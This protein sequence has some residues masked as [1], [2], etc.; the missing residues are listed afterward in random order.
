MGNNMKHKTIRG[1]ISYTSNQPK[2]KGQERG[3]ES[4]IVTIHSDG[5]RTLR[6]HCEIEDAPTVLRDV[7]Y[8]VDSDW[9]PE[10]AFVR[11]TVDDNY[12]GSGW[13]RFSD[14]TAEEETFNVGDGRISKSTDLEKQI[15]ALGCHPLSGDPWF[16]SIYNLADGPG[17]QFFKNL[18]LTS[19]DH[20]GASGP[21]LFSLGCGIEYVGDEK[22]SVAAGDF[23]AHHFRFVDTKDELPEEHPL[24]DLWCTSDGNYTFL[25]AEV[26]GY[27][28]TAYELTKLEISN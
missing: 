6:A 2:R 18:M 13:F 15:R 22:I 11:L 8:T 12:L 21:S 10:E 27:M 23:M 24:Y 16:C 19:P 4:F 25:K 7:T 9:K 1:Q 5:R 14:G 28:Q 26:G 17:K 3:R 20:R